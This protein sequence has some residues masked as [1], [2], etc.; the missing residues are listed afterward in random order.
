M[1]TWLLSSA[2]PAVGHRSRWWPE[3]ISWISYLIRSRSLYL[4]YNWNWIQSD[5]EHHCVPGSVRCAHKIQCLGRTFT[6][7]RNPL[8]I[9][10]YHVVDVMLETV[11]KGVRARGGPFVTCHVFITPVRFDESK[12]Q[13]STKSSKEQ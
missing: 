2:P 1:E 13:M 3:I 8:N 9:R 4:H 7:S 6:G 12:K 11:R 10:L 5:I